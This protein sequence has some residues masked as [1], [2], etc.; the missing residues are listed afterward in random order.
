MVQSKL[1]SNDWSACPAIEQPLVTFVR[2]VREKMN[3]C[4]QLEEIANNLPDRVDAHQCASLAERLPG[5]LG[6]CDDIYQKVIFPLLLRHQ[7]QRYFTPITAE[8]LVSE[9]LMDQGYAVEVSDLL[10]RLANS[11]PIPNVEA[12][13]YL[14]RGFFETV[15]RSSAFDLEYIIPMT[16]RHLTDKELRT[17]SA[18]L[19]GQCH[20]VAVSCI[21]AR[22]TVTNRMLH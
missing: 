8:R 19:K 9:R 18:L 1:P 6:L 14:L 17:L 3:V 22:R 20:V 13:G 21:E 15:R 10:D 11:A 7:S 12:S 4:G 2:L 5:L 16:R